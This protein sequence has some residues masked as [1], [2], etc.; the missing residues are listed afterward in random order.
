M[1]PIT[2]ILAIISLI[3]FISCGKNQPTN[4]TDSFNGI[5]ISRYQGEINWAKVAR[6]YSNIEFVYIK[7]TEGA[8]Y[9]DSKCIENAKGAKK[10]GMKVGGYH[11]FRMTSSPEDQFANYKRIMDK[12]GPDLIPM[13]DVEQN[14]GHTVKEVKR[15]LSRLISLIEK[16]YGVSPMIYGTMRSYNTLCA[17]D[18]NSHILY[19]ARYGYEKPIVKGPSHYSIWQYTDQAVLDGIE[20]RVDLCRFHPSFDSRSIVLHH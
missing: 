5:D 2:P 13:I 17:P 20:K 1:K 6:T 11:F 14:D 4:T 3:I 15:N 8:T 19:I 12:I 9:V 7:C 10:S 18:F 16:E